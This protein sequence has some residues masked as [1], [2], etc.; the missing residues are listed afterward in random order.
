VDATELTARAPKAAEPDPEP[1]GKFYEIQS[2][3]ALSSIAKRYYGDARQYMRIFEA[4]K[5]VIEDPDKIYPR[6]KI[7][8]PAA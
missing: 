8:I 6:Q 1:A 7:R 2:G 5:G 3:D 4:N